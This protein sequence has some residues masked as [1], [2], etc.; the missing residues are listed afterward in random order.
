MQ[1]AIKNRI[2]C[3]ILTQWL[4]INREKENGIEGPV[5]VDKSLLT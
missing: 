4:L 5:S 3:D 2:I 1:I